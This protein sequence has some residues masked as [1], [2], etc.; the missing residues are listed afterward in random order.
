M[1]VKDMSINSVKRKFEN[2]LMSLPNVTGIG[3][4]EHSG[5]EIIIVLVTHK[6]P[7]AELDPSQVVPKSLEGYEVR[8]DEI[9]TVTAQ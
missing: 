7:E 4:G 3:I 6:V 5:R 8:V 9:G 2:Q 1:V